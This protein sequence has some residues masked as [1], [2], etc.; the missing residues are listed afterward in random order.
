[1]SKEFYEIDPKMRLN[2]YEIYQKFCPVLLNGTGMAQK[3]RS[4][5]VGK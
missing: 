3:F 5:L 4:C 2:G 1:M